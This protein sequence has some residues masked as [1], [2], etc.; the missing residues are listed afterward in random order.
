LVAAAGACAAQDEPKAKASPADRL[1][2][3]KKSHAAAEAEY[4]KALEALPDTKEGQEKAEQLWKAFDKGQAERFMQAVEIAK[5]E[6]KSDA[7]FAALEWVLTIPRSYELPAGKPA[8]E[9]MAEH[10]AA[11]PKVGKAVGWVGYFRPHRGENQQAAAA[12][13]DA[14]AKK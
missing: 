11:N 14:V 12:F 2:A 8:L 5:A 1:A 6:P 7:G 9:L 10:H 13:I 3:I 4:Y